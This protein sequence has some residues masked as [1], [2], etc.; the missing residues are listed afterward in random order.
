MCVFVCMDVCKYVCTDYLLAEWG[1]ISAS[2][3][4]LCFVQLR[5][6]MKMLAFF[7]GVRKE[8]ERETNR[9]IKI[10]NKYGERETIA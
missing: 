6:E 3:Y 5:M 9:T 8:R 7:L 10:F 4:G 1:G 2:G